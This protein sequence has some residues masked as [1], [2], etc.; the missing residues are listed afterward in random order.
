MRGITYQEH[1]CRKAHGH[2]R[3]GNPLPTDLFMEMTNAGLDVE[4]EAEAFNNLMEQQ[5]NGN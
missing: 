1:L 3:E 4:R 5:H 2:W